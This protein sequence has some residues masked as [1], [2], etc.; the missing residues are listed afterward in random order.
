MTKNFSKLLPA[1]TVYHKIATRHNIPL[2]YGT[3]RKRNSFI[4]SK[5]DP[6]KEL[7]EETYSKMRDKGGEEHHF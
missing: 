4:I 3:G 1:T 7:V 5:E 2:V 6:C